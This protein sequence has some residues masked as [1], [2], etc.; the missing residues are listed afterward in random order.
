MVRKRSLSIVLAVIMLLS[1]MLLIQPEQVSAA[2]TI[3]YVDSAGGND[4]NNGTSPSTAW[5]SLTKV[6]SVIAFNPG[7]SILLKAGSVWNSQSLS[8]KGSGTTGNPIV[9][10][11]YGTGNKPIINVNKTAFAGVYF[12]NQE[13]WEVNNLEITNFTGTYGSDNTGKYVG[14]HFRI[15]KNTN[16]FDHLYVQ[17]CYIHDVDGDPA[18]HD[19]VI[20]KGTGGIS[21][22]VVATSTADL[23]RFNDVLIQ[24]NTIKY[25]S[26]TGIEVAW[27]G[28]ANQKPAY[29]STN[30]IVRGNVFDH[31]AGD[32]LIFAQVSNGLAEGNVSTYGSDR[33]A[34]G[35]YNAGLWS[36]SSNDIIYQKNEVAYIQNKGGDLSAWDFDLQNGNQTFQYNYSHSNAGGFMLTMGDTTNKN[37]ARYNIS[38]NETVQSPR[39]GSGHNV[40]YYNNVFYNDTGEIRS[41]FTYNNV[42]YNSTNLTY[43]NKYT[44]THDYNAYYNSTVISETNGIYTDPKFVGPNPGDGIS[45]LNGFKLQPSSPLINA[46]TPMTTPGVYDFFGN[47]IYNQTPDIG[48][49]EVP[50][51]AN[52]SFETGALSPWYKWNDA[53]VSTANARTG[54]NSIRV[55]SGPA[56]VEQVITVKP[57]TTYMFTGYAMAPA[58]QEMVMGVKNYGGTEVYTAISSTSYTKGNVTFTTGSTNTAATI[59]FYHPSGNGNAFGD[60]FSVEEKKVTITN[61]NFETGAISPWTTWGTIAMSTTNVRSGTYSAR[62]GNSPASIEQVIPL[63]PNTTYVLSGYAMVPSGQQVF[64]GVKNFGG[65]EVSAAITST[66]YSQGSVTFTTGVANTQGVIYVYRPSGSGNVYTDDITVTEQ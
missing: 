65:A 1:P 55:G 24:D 47:P 40:W 21:F 11:K 35:V 27:S 36:W 64:I 45:T 15:D 31:V 53:G 52:G 28:W 43:S 6:N 22:A 42:F 5:Q 38:A 10:D 63:K 8:P 26:R 54:N 41:N 60:D 44:A 2:G 19:G 58:G 56:S 3:Y 34:T 12:E 33:G 62:I 50:I 51:V 59:Y 39:G 48:A 7:D 37:V 14:I 30:V 23:G 61:G 4:T 49:Y 57:N 32:T 9:I 18:V 16:T 13:Y 17:N 29:Y 46:G 20:D 25:V 66:S